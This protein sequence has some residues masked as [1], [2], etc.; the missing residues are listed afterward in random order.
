MA[1]TFLQPTPI[2]KLALALLRRELVIGGLVNT[3][4]S[5]EF[6]GKVGDTITVRVPARLTGRRRTLRAGT[7][8]TTDEIHEFGVP[9]QLTD[10]AYSSIAVTDEQLTLDIVD[11]GKQVLQPQMKAVAETVEDVIVE[12][13]SG[14]TYGSDIIDIDESAP[15]KSITAANKLLNDR[16]VSKTGRV[17]LMGSGVEKLMLDTELFIRA[18][19][20]GATTA[21]QEA[22][23]GRKFGFLF[24]SSNA[25]DEGDAYA[26]SRDAF[27]AALRAPVV[28]DGASF[29]KSISQDG[30]AL[31][32][33]RDYD[34]VNTRDRSLVDTFV[35]A[36][37]VE[38]ADDPTDPDSATTFLRGVK[39]SL[40]GS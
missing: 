30:F 7:P 25:I 13:I 23:L 18:D 5:D 38:D 9:L 3:D 16:S 10:D 32:W 37:A 14:A 29:G 35:G 11:F 36:V 27:V 8:I 6:A 17:F 33:L 31:R 15:N 21:L 24:V 12:A 26:F 20:S 19:Q 39:L 1:N 40:D 34:Y 4:A 2:S 22:I 28:P